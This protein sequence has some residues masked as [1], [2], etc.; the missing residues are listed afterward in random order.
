MDYCNVL[1]GTAAKL[2][3]APGIVLSGRSVA[4]SHF[5]IFQPYMKPGYR[6]LLRDRHVTFLNN[7]HAGAEDYERWLGEPRGSVRVLHNGF[8]F[9]EIDRSAAQVQMRREFNIPQTAPLV[10]SI[11]RFSE[12]KRPKLAIDMAR[13]IHASRPDVRFL[14]CGDGVL[15]EEMRDYVT[16]L[17]LQGVV[18]L[19]GLVDQTWD[20]LA[21]MD[22]FVLTSRM[23]GLPN[24]LIEAQASGLPVVCTGVGGMAETFAEGETGVCVLDATAK[25]L[26]DSVVSILANDDRRMMMSERA[27][28]FARQTFGIDRMVNE[29]ID[30]YVRAVKEP[31]AQTAFRASA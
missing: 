21:A 30:A 9:P 25:S 13:E 23:E 1:C 10:G 3:G 20:V 7:S 22:C 17:G 4:P 2:V 29:T 11:L 12:E 15:L 31:Q 18:V 5:R 28:D 16:S 24:V 8:E 6:A 26:A 14:F 27:R 19:P